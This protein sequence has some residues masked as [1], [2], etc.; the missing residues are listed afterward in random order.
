MCDWLGTSPVSGYFCKI[1]FANVEKPAGQC[2]AERQRETS[3]KMK[4]FTTS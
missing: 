3:G 1:P 2:A 4:C